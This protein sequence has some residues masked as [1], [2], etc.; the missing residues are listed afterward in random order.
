MTTTY[1]VVVEST[2][3]DRLINIV[4]YYYAD[5]EKASEF[6]AIMNE[7]FIKVNSK[8]NA[9]VIELQPHHSCF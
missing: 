6:A 2:M 4:T 9:R 7:I 8:L 5:K 1:I 3:E